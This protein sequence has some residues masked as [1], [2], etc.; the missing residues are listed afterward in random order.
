MQ[1]Y[2]G[3]FSYGWLE[4]YELRKLIPKHC[5]LKGDCNIGLFSNWHILIRATLLED[6]FYLLSK[7][8]FYIMQHNRSFPMR[9]LKWD[10]MFN[11]K[12][13]TMTVGAWISFPSLP[14]NF[15]GEEAIIS[16]A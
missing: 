9:T 7:P 14:P 16:L 6:Y 12:E 5:E 15:I 3:K 8:T 2:I 13:E 1:L 11:P 10:P 4:I